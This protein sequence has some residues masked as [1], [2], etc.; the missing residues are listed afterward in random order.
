MSVSLS[1]FA[2]ANATSSVHSIMFLSF[3]LSL[4]PRFLGLPA[5]LRLFFT[6]VP[7][8]VFIIVFYLIKRLIMVPLLFLLQISLKFHHTKK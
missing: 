1:M 3:D 4:Y 6:F 8:I 5:L 7:H 2:H